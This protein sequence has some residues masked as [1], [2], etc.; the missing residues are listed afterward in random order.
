MR[1]RGPEGSTPDVSWSDPTKIVR[2]P[3]GRPAAVC[4]WSI[5]TP[6]L[7]DERPP[8][9]AD[10]PP[11]S[12][13]LLHSVSINGWR[14]AIPSDHKPMPWKPW[15]DSCVTLHALEQCAWPSV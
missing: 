9:G 7:T 10:G 8:L 1:L 14:N 13:E 5:L 3:A 15:R 6:I 12:I 4:V 2:Q 11:T